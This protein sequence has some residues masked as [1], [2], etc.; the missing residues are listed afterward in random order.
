MKG[1]TEP[2]CGAQSKKTKQ[3]VMRTL[4]PDKK[5]KVAHTYAYTCYV[6]NRPHTVFWSSRLVI[7]CNVHSMAR[8]KHLNAK[9]FIKAIL[10]T[11]KL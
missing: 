10:T 8:L 11:A 5:T 1:K 4:L 6:L 9:G 3:A 7:D 2:E